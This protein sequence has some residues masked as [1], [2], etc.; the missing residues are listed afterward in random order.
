MKQIISK[1][2]IRINNKIRSYFQTQ[3]VLKDDSYIIALEG[4]DKQGKTTIINMIKDYF[5]HEYKG[6][7]IKYLKIID[8]EYPKKRL[9]I[10]KKF[11][12]YAEQ[13]IRKASN[14]YSTL[15]NS[16]KTLYILD[17]SFLTNYIY[18]YKYSFPY[19][20]SLLH[21]D[22]YFPE[23][24]ITPEVIFYIEKN[25]IKNKIKELYESTQYNVFI[26]K[27]YKPKDNNKFYY[28]EFYHDEYNNDFIF[29][30]RNNLLNQII[31]DENQDRLIEYSCYK[32]NHSEILSKEIID[33]IFNKL[34][35]P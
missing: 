18:N 16:P 14:L 23:I 31:K 27:N 35:N 10:R 1:T 32:K 5:Y 11:E 24:N 17:R 6:N 19:S 12:F 20:M 13:H 2:K 34:I 8:Y 3:C 7:A 22:G 28:D 26:N 21:N 33:F 30:D 15:K 9:T 4:Y 29:Y 25:K